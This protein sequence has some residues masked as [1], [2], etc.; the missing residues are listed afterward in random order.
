M[1]SEPPLTANAAPGLGLPDAS[2]FLPLSNLPVSPIG[3][4]A[5]FVSGLGARSFL[6]GLFIKLL[7]PSASSRFVAAEGAAVALYCLE[8]PP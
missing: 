8:E 7:S 1:Q 3:A 2:H 5:L 4:L 6:S